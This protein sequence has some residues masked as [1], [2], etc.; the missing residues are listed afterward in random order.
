MDLITLPQNPCDLLDFN[1]LKLSAGESYSASSGDREILAVIL[2]GKAN[3]DVN[4]TAFEN[5]GKRPNV[6]SGK[7]HSVYIP[8]DA[9]FH[10][11]KQ[12]D[13]P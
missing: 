2:G 5:V 10:A 3:F 6:F 8:A 12:C 7:P 4:G 9:S 1:L 11:L 13:Q